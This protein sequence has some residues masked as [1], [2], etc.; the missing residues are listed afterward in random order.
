MTLRRR[1]LIASGLTAPFLARA[2]TVATAFAPPPPG[3]LVVFLPPRASQQE[4]VPGERPLADRLAARLAALGFRQAMLD[5]ASHDALWAQEVAAVGGLDDPAGGVLRTEAYAQALTRLARRVAAGSGAALVLVPRLVL[6]QAELAGPKAAWDG[7]L[8]RVPTRAWGDM[9]H[10]AGTVPALSVEITAFAADG[11][12]GFH[13]LGGASLPLR[14]DAGAGRGV[15]RDDLFATAA[16]LDEGLV[17]ALAPLA[18]GRGA[19]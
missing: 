18:A 16:E 6:R 4:F 3:A 15:L 17:I 8:R 9:L 10:F 14:M 11:R 2:Q 7:Q 1:S 12:F 19:P 13:A 5:R